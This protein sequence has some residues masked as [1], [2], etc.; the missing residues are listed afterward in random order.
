VWYH[1]RIHLG[2]A[3]L[4]SVDG[5]CRFG[6]G[7]RLDGQLHSRCLR[8]PAIV[9]SAGYGIYMFFASMC[10]LVRILAY[11]VVPEMNGRRLEDMD[12]LF[13]D[14][15]GDG[16]NGLLRRAV[17]RARRWS[18]ATRR[19]RFLGFEWKRRGCQDET[20]TYNDR[21]KIFVNSND[22]IALLC[23]M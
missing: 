18:E 2:A 23:C 4:A 11:F 7:K 16:E 14:T 9:D 12:K 10:L 17:G 21:V 6:H 19:N 13:G 20:G 8:V 15:S 5:Y 22:S 1:L 3:F